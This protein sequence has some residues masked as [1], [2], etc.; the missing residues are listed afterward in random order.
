MT[1]TEL[2]FGLTATRAGSGDLELELSGLD[3]IDVG[4]VRELVNLANTLPESRSL[5]L[6][7]TGPGFRSA[8]ARERWN[9]W[10]REQADEL[11]AVVGIRCIDPGQR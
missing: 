11:R 6:V 5:V 9:E 8:E 1:R 3:F 7:D 4:G 10:A 2:G